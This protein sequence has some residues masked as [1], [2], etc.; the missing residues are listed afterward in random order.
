MTAGK[1]SPL[2]RDGERCL[3]SL[4]ALVGLAFGGSPSVGIADR[5]AELVGG[6]G[7]DGRPR[8]AAE[9]AS[10][11]ASDH[12]HD[13]GSSGGACAAS[14]RR[15]RDDRQSVCAR[16]AKA[17]RADAVRARAERPVRCGDRA[18]PLMEVGA[19]AVLRRHSA[20]HGVRRRGPL[21]PAQRRATVGRGGAATPDRP[22]LPTRWSPIRP[23]R[24]A[25]SSGSSSIAAR[26]RWRSAS[27]PNTGRPSAGRR[28][29]SRRSPGG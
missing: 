11:V 6:R 23:R 19:R 9:G 12:R 28:R 2:A 16:R 1:P 26:Q 27:A 21:R 17:W 10:P 5:R 7:H 14:A 29:T 25:R 18:P 22:V 8:P 3:R 4:R 15:R 24:R 20:A 13:P